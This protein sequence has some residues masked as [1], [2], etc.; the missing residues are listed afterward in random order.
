MKYLVRQEQNAQ[1]KSMQL[2]ALSRFFEVITW[3][4][5]QVRLIKL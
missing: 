4:Q 2:D 5:G 1:Q 3:V